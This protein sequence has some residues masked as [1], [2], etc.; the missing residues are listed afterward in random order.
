MCPEMSKKFEPVSR[1][2]WDITRRGL[3]CLATAG[4]DVGTQD[5]PSYP[6]NA[7]KTFVAEDLQLRGEKVTLAKTRH[8]TLQGQAGT[9]SLAAHAI[10]F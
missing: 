8:Q 7:E 4:L 10:T 6:N 3:Q 1:D 9:S 5:V 2:S